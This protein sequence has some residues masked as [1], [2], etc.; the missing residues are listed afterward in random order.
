MD[1]NNVLPRLFYIYP[2]DVEA[3]QNKN[4]PEKLHAV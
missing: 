1:N 4:E 3:Y 2:E